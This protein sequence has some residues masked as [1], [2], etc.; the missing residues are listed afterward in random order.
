LRRLIVELRH[1]AVD[2]TAAVEVAALRPSSM[3]WQGLAHTARHLIDTHF[4]SG[5][6]CSPRYR[7]LL[8]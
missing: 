1:C 4:E 3:S 6:Y 2:A 8:N 7:M 5:R